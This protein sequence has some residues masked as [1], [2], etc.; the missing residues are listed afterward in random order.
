MTETETSSGPI[1]LACAAADDTRERL[2]A[3]L[4]SRYSASYRILSSSSAAES[5]ELL[6]RAAADGH[7]VA[8]VLSDDLTEDENEGTIFDVAR[9]LFPDV[10]RGLVVR[11]GSWVDPDVAQAIF[12][13]MTRT[14][15]DYYVVQPR[16]TPDEYFH[17]MVTEFLL[18]WERAAGDHSPDA[19]VL[20][21]DG[22]PRVHE[23]RRFLS[24]AGIR[25]RYAAPGSALAEGTAEETGLP[26]SD[27]PAVRLADGRLLV[28][29]ANAELADAV[30]LTTTLPSHTVDLTIIG[31]GPGGLAAAV[32]AASEG[33][34]TLV[35]E[36][37]SI[38]GQ[39]GSSSLI[40]NYLGFSRGVSG[41]ELSERAYQQAWVFGARFGHTREVVGMEVDDDGF[42]L[43]VAPG[44]TVRARAVVLATGVSYRRLAIPGLDPWVGS[45]VFYG[46]SA[47]EAKAQTGRIVHVVGGGNSAGQAALHLARYA[48]SVSLIVRSPNLAASMSA[49]LIDELSAAG[50]AVLTETKVVGGGGTGDRLDH[51]VLRHRGTGEE[52]TV[53]SHALFITIG[54]A[55]HTGWLP[56]AVLRD[57]WGFVWTGSDVVL[58]GGRRAWSHERAP[59]SL[60]ASVPGFFAIGDVRRGS[61]KRV[62]SA[63]GEGSVVISS[64]HAFLAEQSAEKG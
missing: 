10:R 5:A 20:G 43:H 57:D 7:A 60:E 23:I 13:A 51:L 16:H 6:R 59:G 2:A 45:A 28:D 3:E 38:G 34:D 8:L 42:V 15:I 46:A 56:D 39:A 12:S 35:L 19:I 50:V 44:D 52:T 29:P 26:A 48:A 47:V 31:A 27:A 9:R 11:W 4:Q 25:F 37:E 36:R 22:L 64:V 40:R 55:P 14:L 58:E 41:A 32:Y 30:G 49:Y 53:P 17:R 33:L 18:E 21:R 1:I 63:V 54:A 61:V 62:A 24:R